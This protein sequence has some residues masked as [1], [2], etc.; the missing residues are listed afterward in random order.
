MEPIASSH[1]K[2]NKAEECAEF[3][4][5]EIA[6]GRSPPG[7]S[8]L[9]ES[10]LTQRLG[11]SRSC[12]REALRI[13]ESD[14]LIRVSRGARGGAVVLAPTASTISRQI[15]IYLQLRA[16]TVDELFAARR[17]YEPS[18]ARSIAERR[19]QMALSALAQCVAA[20]EFSVHDRDA[21]NLH[22]A[23]FRSIMLQNCGNPVMQLMGSILD[24]IL[25]RHL[26][27]VRRR[28]PHPAGEADQLTDG[29]RAKQNLVRL[30][31]AGDATKAEKA[32]ATYIQVYW[33]RLSK[34]IGKD[35][36]IEIYAGD[37]PPPPLR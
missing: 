1:A 13:L 25:A 5:H 4:R 17:I 20:Q 7:S 9:P 16:I 33:R 11:I 6:T 12:Y 21:Y 37:A 3:L 18:A 29:V 32:W 28:L 36:T 8:F 23:K 2:L 35:R 22:E 10:Q 31:A 27:H 14:G 24:D 34:L 26:E 19:D 15:G 30:M